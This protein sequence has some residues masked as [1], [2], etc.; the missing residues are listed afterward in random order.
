MQQ[1]GPGLPAVQSFRSQR[2]GFGHEYYSAEEIAAAPLEELA[3]AEKS[4]NKIT[5]PEIVAAEFQKAARDSYR[6]PDKLKW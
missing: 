1:N 6:L 3:L 2:G 5:S 4:R